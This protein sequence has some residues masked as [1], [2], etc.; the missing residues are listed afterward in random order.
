VSNQLVDQFVDIARRI[1]ASFS[2]EQRTLA[3]FSFTE[4]TLRERWSYF[5]EPR[6]GVAIGEFTRPQRKAVHAML[7]AI[8]SPHS[9]AQAVT[10]MALEDVL[11]HREGHRMDRHAG[12]YFLAL[13]GEPSHAGPWGWRFEGHHLSVNIGVIDDQLTITPFFFGANPATVAYHG[14]AIIAPLNQEQRL[15]RALLQELGTAGRR[16]AIVSDQAPADIYT[17]NT[18][19]VPDSIEP[20]GIPMSSMGPTA[21][22]IVQSLLELYMDRFTL[23]V[24]A[25]RLADLSPNEIFF[26]WEGSV[27]QGT[28]HYYRLHAG[29]T[30]IEYDN[31]AN[32]AN[33]IHSVIR[34]PSADFGV[35][36]LARHHARS[37][38]QP[39]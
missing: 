24:A 25:A 8:L 6:A 32:E 35:D 29:K 27:E 5:P 21:A 17:R 7:A 26:A 31:T 13:F 14:A 4:T 33:H 3:R 16:M 23:E 19:H 2:E 20:R 36:L 30:I 37:H 12:D 28:G 11:D 10:I 1:L 38:S 22:K 39:G 9:Y 15:G 34:V 18:A